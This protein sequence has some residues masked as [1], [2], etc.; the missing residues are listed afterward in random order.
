M[1]LAGDLIDGLI[2]QN[3]IVLDIRL[4]TGVWEMVLNYVT[5]V[6]AVVV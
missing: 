5:N 3:A 4:V 1:V 6:V 2:V